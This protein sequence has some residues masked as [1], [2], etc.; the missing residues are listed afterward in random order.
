MEQNFWLQVGADTVARQSCYHTFVPCNLDF[1]GCCP[2]GLEATRSSTYQK[3]KFGPA[4]QLSDA[5]SPS[6]KMKNCND[7]DCSIQRKL[8]EPRNT[9][10]TEILFHDLACIRDWTLLW[11]WARTFILVEGSKEMLA[12][13][14][15]S[16]L[17][18][19]LTSYNPIFKDPN[20][21]A[22]SRRSNKIWA[23]CV[24]VHVEVLARADQHNVARSHVTR[25]TRRH[26]ECS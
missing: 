19:L 21:T 25:F 24:P 6:P 4:S 20:K 5:T 15:P 1:Y 9:S 2:L 3:F 14:V 23:G 10:T 26:V 11:K 8:L 16:A 7:L 12:F 13:Q 17:D 22:A 18:D